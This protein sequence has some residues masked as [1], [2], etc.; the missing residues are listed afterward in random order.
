MPTE[1]IT[2]VTAATTEMNDAK[3]RYDMH[4]SVFGIVQ[5]KETTAPK[6]MKTMVQ[7]AWLVVTFIMMAKVRTCEAMTKTICELAPVI[8]MVVPRVHTEEE[9]LPSSENLPTPFSK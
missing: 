5:M 3:E 1:T 9:K 8:L 7:V 6:T 2:T 4:F